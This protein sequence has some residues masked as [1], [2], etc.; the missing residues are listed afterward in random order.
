MIC[1]KLLSFLKFDNGN[2]QY[3]PSSKQNYYSV[4]MS[5]SKVPSRS[6][7]IN[8]TPIWGWTGLLKVYSIAPTKDWISTGLLASY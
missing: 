8:L 4:K 7:E 1:E 3:L 2:K 5:P 6:G